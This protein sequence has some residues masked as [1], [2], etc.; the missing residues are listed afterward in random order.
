MR[1]TTK[2][3]GSP[4]DIVTMESAFERFKQLLDRSA[5]SFICTPNTEII[6]SARND[7]K[8]IE[9]LKSSDMNIPDGIGLI[10]ASKIHKLGLITR[11]TGID[12]MGEILKFCNYS[13]KS[14][15]ILGGKPGVAEM[16][17]Y[18]I[19]EKFPNIDVKGYR[20]GY[21]KKEEEKDII[22][23]INNL[24]PDI[25]FVALG[26]PKQ[27]MFMYGYR[28]DLNVKVALGVGGCV[29]IWA[30]TTK[31]APKIFRILGLEWFYRLI[32]E[33]WRFKRMM[34]LPKFMFQVLTSKDIS[35]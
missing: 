32:K 34:V 20:H 24:S 13:R 27:E 21:F 22:E 8:L 16:A 6:M 7:E 17:V 11:V 26:V 9:A 31:R 15:Y 2:I 12:L 10:I 19:K 4:I 5:F 28:K 1:K 14:I 3:Y 18:N 23:N 30:G 33:P 29:D 35:N 25:L